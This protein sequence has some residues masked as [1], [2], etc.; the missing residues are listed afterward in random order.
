MQFLAHDHGGPGDA[1]HGHR[2]SIDDSLDFVNTLELDRGGVTEELASP[3][4]ALA[5]LE[6][7]GLI[8]ADERR[9]EL[10]RYQA[11]PAAGAAALAELRSVRGSMRDLL[12]ALA[13]RRAPPPAS[14]ESLNRAIRVPY[15]SE[16][17]AVPDGV[18]V[19]H[20]HPDDP[21]A[22]ALARLVEG[23]LE[24][25]VAGRPDR[26]RV[27]ANDVCRWVFTDRSRGGRRKWCSMAGCGNRAKAA[28]HRARARLDDGPQVP[29][30]R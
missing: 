18:E 15:V 27:C 11:D 9:S 5:W 21:I 2:A 13:A 28:R 3:A 4:E 25:L 12:E 24:E 7:R 29:G 1:G 8:H 14:V 22:G 20:R 17:V 26:L 30:E 6:G 16:L 23:L 19:G 10:T